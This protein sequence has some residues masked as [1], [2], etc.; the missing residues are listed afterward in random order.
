[1]E[2]EEDGHDTAAAHNHDGC[3]LAADDISE[4]DDKIAVAEHKGD[5]ADHS[6]RCCTD[7]AAEHG[8]CIAVAAEEMVEGRKADNDQIVDDR[9]ED[10]MVVVDVEL[11]AL[12]VVE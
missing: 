10:N 4:A 5:E 12:K 1:M 3:S 2:H 7:M 6:L 8:C 11:D 9:T